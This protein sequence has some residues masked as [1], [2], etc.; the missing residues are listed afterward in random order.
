MIIVFIYPN[1][2]PMVNEAGLQS[3]IPGN[4]SILFAEKFPG[5][6]NDYCFRSSFHFST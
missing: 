2:I 4:V 1:K 6:D 5:I 3:K